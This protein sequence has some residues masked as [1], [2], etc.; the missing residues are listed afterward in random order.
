MNN[1]EVIY[2]GKKATTEQIFID[3]QNQIN[4]C[5]A[6]NL[7]L[8]FKDKNG[9]YQSFITDMMA[10]ELYFL[11]AMLKRRAVRQLEE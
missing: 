10:E 11:G 7:A 5:N 9:D 1:I 6:E 8:I 4:K 2:T 3:A